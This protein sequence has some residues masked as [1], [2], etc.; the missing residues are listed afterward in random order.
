MATSGQPLFQWNAKRHAFRGGRKILD[1]HLRMKPTILG[2]FLLTLAVGALGGGVLWYLHMPL[3]WLLGAMIACGIG[4]LL[5]LPLA[6]PAFARP[7]MTATIGAM[8]GTS[9]S[10][11]VFEHVGLWIVSLCG[12]GV[13]IA[14]AGSV[15]YLYFRLIAGFDH[16]TAYFSAMPG[17]LVEMVTLGAERGGDEK[18]IA[19][20]HAARI[21][22]VV[23]CLPFLIQLVTGQ[24]IAR[25]GSNFIPVST[26]QFE[27]LLWF[28]A[29]MALGVAL[30]TVLR[31]PARYLLGPMAVSASLHYFGLTDFQLP[32]PALGAAQ[33]IIGATVGCRF[34]NTPSRMILGVIGLSIGST[35][36]LLCTSLTFALMISMWTGDRLVGLVLA[37]SP[38]GVAEMSLIALSLGIEVPFVV[39]HHIVR[40]LL[41]V[42]GSTAVFRFTKNRL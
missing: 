37:Y 32:S 7:P 13:F 40:V 17:G 42:A 29:A 23:L 2:K 1:L 3:A 8:L 19:L 5:R 18:M 16:A 26:V 22:L 15:T 20:I 10:P 6:L 31:F 4:A 24:A 30:G 21:F 14:V 38:G 11:S 12:L 33:V 28:L 36:L 27:D 41:V 25:S 35:L 34:V 9:F 39:L